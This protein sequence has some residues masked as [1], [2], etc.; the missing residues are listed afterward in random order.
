M[1]GIGIACDGEFID[2]HPSPDVFSPRIYAIGEALCIVLIGYILVQWNYLPAAAAGGLG[3]MAGKIALPALVF[4]S[5]A[6]LDASAVNIS[7]VMAVVGAK[8][9][10]MIIALLF[11]V[12]MAKNNRL[13][14]AGLVALCTTQS[15]DMALGLPVLRALFGDGPRVDLL[16]VIA[17]ASAILVTPVDV[18]VLEFAKSKAQAIEGEPPG[19]CA[20]LLKVA[21]QVV[22]SPLIVCVF[23]G[24]VCNV[25]FHQIFDLPAGEIP[26]FLERVCGTIGGVFPGIALFLTGM[27]M[28]NKESKSHAKKGSDG[29][30][31][32]VVGVVITLLK[33]IVSPMIARFLAQGLSAEPSIQACKDGL[34]SECCNN[35]L[36]CDSCFSFLVGAI[37]SG[38]ANVAII[39]SYGLPVAAAANG[40]VYVAPVNHVSHFCDA[41][42]FF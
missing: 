5:M 41:R 13:G 34:Q 3:P 20:L 16:F 15:N 10:V 31:M 40:V 37:P 9:V 29:N 22:T 1:C 21:K 4:R 30:L 18:T 11:G 12:C 28:I 38:A 39:G 33:G 42:L 19:L 2:F 8:W 23:L 36:L 7:I 14:M 17:A 6:K 35:P 26:Y 25:I 32:I 27:G 24:L